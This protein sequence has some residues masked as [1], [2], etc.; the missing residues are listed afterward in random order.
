MSRTLLIE[1]DRFLI[2]DLSTFI[3]YEGHTCEVY[4][5]PDDVLDNIQNLGDFDVV[6]LDIMMSRG[7][8]LQEENP[9]FETG[10]LLYQR[11]REKFPELPIIII[12]AKNFDDMKI[13]F[14]QE[15]HVDTVSKPFDST[16]SELIS[17]IP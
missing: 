8:Y 2:E 4:T 17:R 16:A 12:S 5:G 3:E 9:S 11:I 14:A 10:E 7:S 13:D 1:D 15:E 6:I